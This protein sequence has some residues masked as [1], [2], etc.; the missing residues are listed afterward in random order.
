[1]SAPFDNPSF[2]MMCDR[3]SAEWATTPCPSVLGSVAI[4]VIDHPG[5]L[6]DLYLVTLCTCRRTFIHDAFRRVRCVGSESEI[7]T[8]KKP[9]VITAQAL[10]ET[11]G[12]TWPSTMP[13]HPQ[14]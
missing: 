5:E 4:D 3:R 6:A 2:V 8:Q 1:M 11:D 9:S 7:R 13:G 10:L 14:W 12:L